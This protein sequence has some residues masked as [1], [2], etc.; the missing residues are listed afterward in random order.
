MSVPGQNH[1]D[2]WF[3]AWWKEILEDSKIIYGGRLFEFS[4]QGPAN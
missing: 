4:D 3:G 2:P 1:R